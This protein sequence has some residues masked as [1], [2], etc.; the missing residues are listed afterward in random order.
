MK[1]FYSRSYFF[2]IIFVLIGICFCA[3]ANS[4]KNK[5]NTTESNKSELY[6]MHAGSLSVPFKEIAKAFMEKNP[7]IIIKL[8]SGGSVA[9]ARKITE[10]GQYCDVFA[11]A[12][13][14]VVDKMLIPEYASYNIKFACNEMVIA[15]NRTKKKY[16]INAQN[17]F[18]I[19]SL[20][21]VEYGRS[22][23]NSDPC[24][25][26]TEMVLQ[27]AS[28][29]YNDKNIL[30]L[31]EKDKNN[32]RPKEVDLLAL[33]QSNNIDYI[34][35]YKSVAIQHQLNYITLSDSINLGNPEFNN[36]YANAKVKIN[37]QKPGTFI[38]H[39]GEAMLY[40]VTVLNQTKNLQNANLFLEFLLHK[41]GGRKIM[42]NHG[43][44]DNIMIKAEEIKYLPQN[45]KNLLNH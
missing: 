7:H 44:K 15:F 33:I 37:G 36:W 14:Q 13:Y 6:I 8:E 29:Y 40:S 27:L 9:N 43:Q 39:T 30:K 12:D 24:G 25:Y 19:L 45:I 41:N 35:I 23:P 26:R 38:T 1:N 3:C 42:N 28:K 2:I 32:I 31:L 5:Q 11:S 20:D 16:N 4:A 10:L 34:F 21:D 22:D 17:W 18:N